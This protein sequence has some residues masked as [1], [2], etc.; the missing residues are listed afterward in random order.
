MAVKELLLLAFILTGLTAYVYGQTV[1]TTTTT[2]V[3]TVQPTTYVTE[4]TISGTTVVATLE[5]PGY[6]LV[7]ELRQPDS[8]CTITFTAQPPPNTITIP[9]TTATVSYPG[10]TT[11]VVLTV[12]TVASTVTYVV[13]GGTTTRTGFEVLPVEMQGFTFTAPLYGVVVERCNRVT[14]TNIYTYILESAPATIRIVFEGFSLTYSFT[15]TT[16]SLD[17][18]IPEIQLTTTITSIRAGETTR[19]TSRFEGLT[20]TTEEVVQPTTIRS[21]V[22]V[23]GTTRTETITLLVT[24]TSPTTTVGAPSIPVVGGELDILTLGT[25]AAFVVVVAVAVAALVLRR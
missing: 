2:R 16:I 23:P 22:T 12:E 8:T 19:Y 1:I 25:I 3:V 4:T 7:V 18:G 10:T 24:V 5:I 14:G 13:G 20:T 6:T 17:G 9:G 21:T 11:T 15:G